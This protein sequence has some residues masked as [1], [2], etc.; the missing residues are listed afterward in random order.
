VSPPKVTAAGPV[1]RDRNRKLEALFEAAVELPAPERAAF[2]DRACGHDHAL[3]RELDAL[4]VAA[5]TFASRDRSTAMLRGQRDHDDTEVTPGA[6]ACGPRD[7]AG[8]A[9]GTAIEQYELIRRLGSGGMGDVFLA[10]DT[11]LARRVAVKFLQHPNRALAE[12]FL[13]EAQATARCTH[14]NIVVIHDVREHGRVPFMVL[15]Y[16]R[17]QTLGELIGDGK[18]PPVRAVQLMAPV[19]RA[20]VCAH[21]HKIVHRDLKP[22]N[23]FMTD[24]GTIK[25]LDFGVAKI[26]PGTHGPVNVLAST[27]GVS[28][29]SLD[30]PSEITHDGVLVGTVP[31]MSPEQWGADTVDARTDLWAVGI[32]LYRMVVGRHPLAPLDGRHLMVT[33]VLEQPMPSAH[34]AGADMPPELADIIDACLKKRKAERMPSATKLLAALEPLLPGQ[35]PAELHAGDN[36]YAGL[37]AFQEA[38]AGRFFGRTRE[39]GTVVARLHGTPLIGIVGPSGVGKSSFVRAGII[40]ALKQSGEPWEAMV[41]R[42]GRHPMAALANVVVPMLSTGNNDVTAQVAEHQIAL[43]RLY[44]EPGYLGTILR[45]RARTHARKILLFVDQFEELFTLNREA[46]ERRAFTACLTG[47]ADDP[48][49]PLRLMLSIRSDF[50]DRMAEDQRFMSD[51]APGLF[52]L[53]PPDRVGLRDAIVRPLDMVRHRFEAPAMV[54]HMLDTLQAT[55][56]CLPL[57]QFAASKLWDARD[58]DRRILTEHSYRQLGGVAGALATHADAVLAALPPRAQALARTLILQLVTPERTRAIASVTELCAL[59]EVPDEA[60]RVIHQLVDARLLVIQRSSRAGGA[61]VEIVHESLIHSWPTL[62]HWLDENQEDAAFL[63]QLRTAAKQWEARGYSPDL[64]WRGD[65]LAEARSWRRR[66]RGVLPTLHDNFLNASFALAARAAR[67]KRT[68]VAGTIAFLSLLVV[69]AAVALVTI[70][71]AEQTARAAEK[72]ASEQAVAAQEAEKR[73]SDQA[74]VAREAEKRANE[75]AIA[76]RKAER[77]ALAANEKIREQ[78]EIIQQKESARWK[79]ETKAKKA[80]SS[81]H[82]AHSRAEDATE[83]AEKAQEEKKELN[84]K[85]L[86]APVRKSLREKPVQ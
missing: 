45:S 30:V 29:T 37:N 4:L 64:L 2:L 66:Y 33:A 12:R 54:E 76:A 27:A 24:T 79:A 17:G 47:M 26:V 60:E 21:Q 57:L 75:Q 69:A 40:P 15:E 83:A 70:R 32:M 22:A 63:E 55:P 74:V 14:E 11:R 20:L 68:M 34:N 5:P 10:R 81:A 53:A 62:A 6:D 73:A 3:R 61:T 77:L 42:P 59:T 7:S 19:V 51:L 84:N 9:P 41:I 65:T 71:E 48:L 58:R 86:G 13:L 38:D 80:E 1:N 46:D 43:Q 52:F 25:V 23:I 16:L 35:R 18:L 67:V 36:P 50:L 31:Y 28:A 85:A 49:S 56:G 82:A 39:V 8:L 78:L 72:H 44:Q